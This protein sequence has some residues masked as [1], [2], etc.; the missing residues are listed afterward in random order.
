MADVLTYW[1]GHAANLVDQFAADRA[2]YWHSIAKC[3]GPLPLAVAG[4][5]CLREGG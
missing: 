5:V 3:V 2:Y 1:R 4:T